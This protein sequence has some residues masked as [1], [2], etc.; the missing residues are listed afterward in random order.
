MKI[1]TYLETK[2]STLSRNVSAFWSLRLAAGRD[3]VPLVLVEAVD[4]FPLVVGCDA[5]PL[6]STA[7]CGRVNVPLLIASKSS[8][9]GFALVLHISSIERR[10]LISEL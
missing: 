2:S 9:V 6:G 3:A 1:G 4:V 7:V 5:A 8:G 10:L